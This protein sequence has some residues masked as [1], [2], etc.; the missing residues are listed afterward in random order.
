MDAVDAGSVRT[1][2]GYDGPPDVDPDGPA[3]GDAE[4]ESS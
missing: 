3:D 4:P 2:L 1:P